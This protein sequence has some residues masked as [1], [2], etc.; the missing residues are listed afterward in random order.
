[1][2]RAF[3]F[4]FTLAFTQLIYACHM[5]LHPYILKI[6]KALNSTIIEKSDCTQQ[7]QEHILNF[8][9]NSEGTLLTNRISSII[10]MQEDVTFNQ[11]KVT[12]YN[13]NQIIN[14]YFKNND[15]VIRNISPLHTK[16]NLGLNS[17]PS[18]SF[19]C[20]SC[21]TPGSHTIQARIGNK[22]MWIKIETYRR[23]TGYKAKNTIT[24]MTPIIT[25]KDFRRSVFLSQKKQSY[26]TD[27]DNIH[28]YRPTRNISSGEYLRN[29][30]LIPKNLITR[31]QRVKMIINNKSLHVKSTGRALQSGKFGEFIEIENPKSKKKTLA[32]VID[33]NKVLVEL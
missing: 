33:F 9:N 31:G 12:V 4:I 20:P 1:M 25:S 2:V 30:D 16:N 23:I 5:T 28:F 21:T 6:G 24:L 10:K 13:L 14:K 18:F 19:E 26:F 22:K 17:K 32:R 7:T 11:K 8:I 27:I 29:N 15:I 3:I